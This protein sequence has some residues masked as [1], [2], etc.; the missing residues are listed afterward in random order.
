[1]LI[2]S[3]QTSGGIPLSPGTDDRIAAAE[4]LYARQQERQTVGERIGVRSEARPPPKVEALRRRMRMIPR[5]GAEGRRTL[6]D[7]EAEEESEDLEAYLSTEP[8]A[9]ANDDLRIGGQAMWQSLG[10]NAEGWKESETYWRAQQ[11]ATAM[12]IN[13][14]N[15]ANERREFNI[16]PIQNEMDKATDDLNRLP[17]DVLSGGYSPEKETQYRQALETVAFG[18]KALASTLSPEA[19]ADISRFTGEA[20]A[21]WAWSRGQEE[22]LRIDRI[23]AQMES[24]T[25]TRAANDAMARGLLG[26][27]SFGQ[28]LMHGDLFVE[29]GQLLQK[30]SPIQVASAMPDIPQ[31]P[32]FDPGG[33]F[34]NKGIFD[35]AAGGVGT[36]SQR[37]DAVS[38]VGSEQVS[39][40]IPGPGTAAYRLSELFILKPMMEVAT[41]PFGI[42]TEIISNKMQ[43]L[44]VVDPGVSLALP[45]AGV[46]FY[47]G[48]T[49]EIRERPVEAV[50]LFGISAALPGVLGGLGWLGRSAAVSTGLINF[51][52]AMGAAT[53]AAGVVEKSAM[54]YIGISWGQSVIERVGGGAIPSHMGPGP[55]E[56]PRVLSF[57]NIS[58]LP[59]GEEAAYRI[60]RIATGEAAPAVAGLAVGMWAWPRGVGWLRTRDMQEI[61][62]ESIG[63]PAEQGFAISQRITERSLTK[64]FNVGTN[65]PYPSEM[66][67]TGAPPDYVPS[68]ARLPTDMPGDV[69]LWTGWEHTPIPSRLTGRFNLATGQSASE[70]NDAMYGASTAMSYFTK[71]GSGSSPKLIGLD[72]PV[73]ALDPAIMHT[74][75]SG[76][77]TF[78]SRVQAGGYPAMN[79]YL[80]A[81]PRGVGYMPMMKSEYEAVVAGELGDFG[82]KYFTRVAGVR[83]PIVE[84]KAYSGLSSE[85]MEG[86]SVINIPGIGLGNLA[87]SYHIQARS[88]V[89]GAL[90]SVVSGTSYSDISRMASSYR[91]PE[92]VSP[93][94]SRSSARLPSSP[95]LSELSGGSISGSSVS[96][97]SIS[98]PSVASVSAP[99]GPS[100]RAPSISIPYYPSSPPSSPP[101]VPPH[102]PPEIVIGD[103]RKR[104]RFP[105]IRVNVR[106]WAI[107][108]P[109]P[110]IESVFGSLGDFGF[111]NIKL[112]R[113]SL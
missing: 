78:P 96:R 104:Q 68:S 72:A 1:M 102:V 90:S 12:G 16:V 112:P 33:I 71:T 88:Y 41:G 36:L 66:S 11:I 98:A 95:S 48:A 56:S 57:G 74:Q 99:S 94:M 93:P 46:A 105:Q 85:V 101:Y 87:A 18:Q 61:K 76:V 69:I 44:G 17:G 10:G 108:N 4:G 31:A 14:E 75:V 45:D 70:I 64:S 60:G 84:T 38:R 100:Y 51:P 73:A 111:S 62:M 32:G 24:F 34:T 106:E 37:Y 7:D 29:G 25:A 59:T 79:A 65:L 89:S 80:K 81:A 42:G 50:A 97:S 82:G 19:Q 27:A 107:K 3:R 5:R 21:A 110:N 30:I 63:Y 113:L 8:I 86:R 83:V 13:P 20:N 49:V 26:M 6:L 109:V 103:F 53:L 40:I 91:L 22:N 43:A 55:G 39:A 23:I 35:V 77:A 28:A 15:L 47:R 2:P 92:S 9:Q 52:R 58:D 67:I 54:G